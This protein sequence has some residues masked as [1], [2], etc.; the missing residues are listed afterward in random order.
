MRL[1]CVEHMTFDLRRTIVEPQ[2]IREIPEMN[3]PVFWLAVFGHQQHFAE[4]N[5]SKECRAPFGKER[6]VVDKPTQ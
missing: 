6:K 2:V 1:D 4:P 5:H 3:D